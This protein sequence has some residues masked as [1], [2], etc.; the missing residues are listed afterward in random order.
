M[1]CTRR[2]HLV[3]RYESALR[4]Y[5][6][7]VQ[8]LKDRCAAAEA[9]ANPEIDDLHRRMEA[10]RDELDRHSREHRCGYREVGSGAEV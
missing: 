10:A 3:A 6:A 8:G 1:Y 9:E 2:E 5:R 7:A 4:K